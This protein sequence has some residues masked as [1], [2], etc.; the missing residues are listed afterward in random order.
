MKKIIF[1]VA[2]ALLSMPFAMGQR[3]KIKVAN[4]QT[5][6]WRYEIQNEAVGAGNTALVKVWSY[7]KK[8]A[9][10]RNQSLKN[11]VHALIFKGAPGN[12]K[13]SKRSKSLA[14]LISQ[15]HSE[16]LYASVFESFFAEGGEYMK[17]ATLANAGEAGSVEKIGREY[18]VATY[19]TVEYTELRRWLEKKGIIKPLP[20]VAVGKQPSIMV[21][22]SDLWCI[23]QGFY[24]EVD[25][26]GTIEKIPDYGRALQEDANLLLVM[27]KI[28]E[29][30]SERGFPLVD[31]EASLKRLK[32]EDAEMSLTYS[33]DTGAELAENPIERLSRVAKADIWM[34]I[35]WSLNRMGPRASITFNLQGKDAYSDKQIA[36]SSGTCPPAFASTI[37]VPVYLAEHV[38]ANINPFND[39]LTAYFNDL[40]LNGREIRFSCKRW[41]DWEY[42]FESEFEDEELCDIIEELVAENA[43]NGKYGSPNISENKMDFTQLRIPLTNAKGRDLDARNWAKTIRRTLKEKYGIESKLVGKGLGQAILILGGK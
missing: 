27:S 3:H 36:A 29:L 14:P 28:G 40:A 15:P 10:A 6:E 33:K 25:N 22:P 23:K 5:K 35:T 18:R 32:D 1:L 4:A 17:F 43:L 7:S 34:Q 11:A 13:V 12:E 19:V 37:E 31:L 20:E 41:A 8:V 39:Q 24:T 30:M 38:G 2:F 42:D 26:Q 16:E 9:V 21:V